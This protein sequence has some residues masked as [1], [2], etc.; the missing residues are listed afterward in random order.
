[1]SKK[2]LRKLAVIFEDSRFGGPHYQ[3]INN[4]SFLTKNFDTK[5]LISNFENKIFKKKLRSKEI[6]HKESNI[7]YLSLNLKKFF[8]YLFYFFTDIKIIKKFIKENRIEVVYVAGGSNNF[9]TIIACLNLK[10][11]IIWHIHDTHSNWFL[12]KIFQKLY[13]Y[14]SKIIFAS[15]KSKNFYTK[16]FKKKFSCIVLQSSIEDRKFQRVE[17]SNNKF[18]VGTVGNFNK[19]KNQ[20][21]FLKIA[22][23]FKNDKNINFKIIGNVWETQKSYYQSC[24]KY[25]SKNNIK[26]VKILH[27]CKDVIANIRK[28]DVFL[29]TSLHESSPI[30]LW[31][32]M[33]QKKPI[34]SSD[35]GD[36][37]YLMKLKKFG[38]ILNDY[39]EKKFIFAIKMILKKSKMRKIF[40]NNS[41][42]LYKKNFTKKKYEKKFLSF[43]QDII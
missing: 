25:I 36:L 24:I 7:Y 9:K 26:N 33:S 23:N 15:N 30:V 19:I 41:Y 16:S 29:L 21:F 31:E 39:D 1:M 42:T 13:I 43:V 12:V 18:T 6:T 38:Y 3:F 22:N 10:V 27:N 37:R 8:F 11:K 34:I 20:L 32:A 2:R 4:Y 35:V 28:F 14:C 5:I 17:L 40:S